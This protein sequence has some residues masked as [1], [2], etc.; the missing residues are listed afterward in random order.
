MEVT[1][2]SPTPVQFIFASLLAFL[3]PCNLLLN[4]SPRLRPTRGRWVSHYRTPLVPRNSTNPD[5]TTRG[6]QWE[7]SASFFP[8][9]QTYLFVS[10]LQRCF[11]LRYILDRVRMVPLENA[12]CIPRGH[13]SA[14][15]CRLLKVG[16]G[17]CQQ[18]TLWE[19]PGP[20][21]LVEKALSVCQSAQT[22]ARIY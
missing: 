14:Q 19:A 22:L 4:Q 2:C 20:A 17:W 21:S 18:A 6:K 8:E 11:C 7:P 10:S 16:L 3:S 9:I 5:I 1:R 13:T 12:L 15:H